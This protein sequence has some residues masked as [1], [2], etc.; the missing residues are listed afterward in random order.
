MKTKFL[1]PLA[2][3][4]VLAGN[5]LATTSIAGHYTWLIGTLNATV[6]PSSSAQT[7]SI[8]VGTTVHS[9][10]NTIVCGN[11]AGSFAS[12]TNFAVLE[13]SSQPFTASFTTTHLIAFSPLDGSGAKGARS[14]PMTSAGVL[15]AN[16]AFLINSPTA[17]VQMNL[18]LY[19]PSFTLGTMNFV[20]GMSSHVGVPL[21]SYSLTI[22][23]TSGGSGT[24]TFP[25]SAIPLNQVDFTAVGTGN[26]GLGGQSTDNTVICAGQVTGTLTYMTAAH[27]NFTTAV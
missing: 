11:P 17:Y 27:L 10:P 9:V 18:E 3:F 26:I 6:T 4:F 19:Y 16:V 23:A 12:G 8:K 2:S 22:P 25:T 1:L 5:A 14:I 24:V 20:N 13:S 15:T 21:S 7:I